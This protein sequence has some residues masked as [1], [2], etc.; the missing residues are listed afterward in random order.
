M[1]SAP[2]CLRL[3]GFENVLLDA[4]D[5]VQIGGD[6][7]R[8]LVA[9]ANDLE[10]MSGFVQIVFEWQLSY[11]HELWFE[12]GRERISLRGV[13]GSVRRIQEGSNTYYLTGFN[14]T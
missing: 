7:H 1:C 9:R 4:E 2:F 8:L 14:L 10:R 3:T 11:G 5:R 13:F 6:V 12:R